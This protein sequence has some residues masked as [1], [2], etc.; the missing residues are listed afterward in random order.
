MQR[1]FFSTL[2]RF[3]RLWPGSPSKLG[4]FEGSAEVWQCCNYCLLFA[5]R[6]DRWESNISQSLPRAARET[7]AIFR[8]YPTILYTFLPMHHHLATKNA[9]ECCFS[10][11]H[12]LLAVVA[13]AS[14]T[15]S[16]PLAASHRLFLH[17]G[18][19]PET[20][21]LVFSLH[22]R[23]LLKKKKIYVEFWIKSS[24]K[25][26][27]VYIN[28]RRWIKRSRN[29]YVGPSHER[30]F[31]WKGPACWASCFVLLIKQ[32]CISQMVGGGA[33][34]KEVWNL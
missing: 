9:P 26:I 12:I 31:V 2:I 28:T 6:R 22:V 29:Q 30:L 4:L 1:L 34:G 11:S 15:P 32:Q 33:D 7:G 24:A 14:V 16:A 13:D 21:K 3:V 17:T 10:I 20:S 25:W 27:I 19:A 18:P 8:T 5:V 23:S